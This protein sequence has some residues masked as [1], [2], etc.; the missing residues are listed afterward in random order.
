M[1][2]IEPYRPPGVDRLTSQGRQLLRRVR[3]V[4][5]NA[6]V[7]GRKAELEEQIE[8]MT[9]EQRIIN[10]DKLRGLV[11]QKVRIAQAQASLG[12]ADDISQAMTSAAIRKITLDI[13]VEIMVNY[14][15]R[16]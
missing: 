14:G 3:E 5:A 13:M 12:A 15:T 9:A 10:V 1:G 11:E 4:E 7:R 16:R 2:E 6:I 8:L